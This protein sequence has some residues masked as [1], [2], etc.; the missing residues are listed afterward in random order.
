M[1]TKNVK[2]HDCFLHSKFVWCTGS[3]DIYECTIC[4]EVIIKNCDY[5]N[6]VSQ[7]YDICDNCDPIDFPL[8]NRCIG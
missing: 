1:I 8:C 2:N 4:G 5:D 7:D 3:V 6:T